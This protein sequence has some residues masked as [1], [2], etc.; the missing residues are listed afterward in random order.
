MKKWLLLI[1]AILILFFVG[2]YVFIPSNIEISG[3]TTAKATRD[4]SVRT[5]SSE[6]KWREW[7]NY[8]NT[9]KNAAENTKGIFRND[10]FTYKLKQSGFNTSLIS[11]GYKNKTTDGKITV[12]QLAD[13]SVAIILQTSLTGSSNPFVRMQQ[14]FDAVSL[15]KNIEQVLVSL[16]SFVEKDENIYGIKISETTTKDSFLIS[17]KQMFTHQPSMNN[18]YK[19]ID[20]LKEYALKNNCEQVDAP[21]LNIS[22]ESDEYRV[23][24]AL[25]INKPVIALPPVSYIKMANGNF[26]KTRVQGGP[27]TVQ[28][29]LQQLQ[30]YFQDYN[31]TSMAITFQYLVTDRNKEA[32]TTKWITEIYAPVM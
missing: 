10:Y 2:V 13:N 25:P 18:V 4:G 15:K 9:Q 29:A 16:K 27:A 31:K 5:I 7:W 22:T 14:Y 12:L 28:N 17:K 6:S 26:M 24:V 32:D 23:M 20:D 30:L 1:A 21:M 3:S 8:N 19:L 11:I